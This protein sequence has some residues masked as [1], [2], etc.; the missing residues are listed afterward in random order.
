LPE[1]AGRELKTALL[2]FQRQGV[3]ALV[4][5]MYLYNMWST[6]NQ[7]TAA[8]VSRQ[9]LRRSRRPRPFHVPQALANASEADA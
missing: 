2:W 7:E 3:D 6:P 8:E 4:T 1:L 9:R 5:A